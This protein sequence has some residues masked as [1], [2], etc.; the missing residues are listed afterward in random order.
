V[1][2]VARSPRTLWRRSGERVVL[3]N[4]DGGELH[5]LEGTGA[6]VWLYLAAPTPV[7]ALVSG[8]AQQFEIAEAE[9]A[10]DLDAF[11]EE[12]AGRGVLVL[13]ER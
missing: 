3:R 6:L 2:T 1:R 5:V 4:R 11:V 10:D 9:V 8:F 7:T 12:L 13:S